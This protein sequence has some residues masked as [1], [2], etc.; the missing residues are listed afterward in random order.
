MSFRFQGSPIQSIISGLLFSASLLLAQETYLW[1]TNAS[2]ELS[3]SFG[4]YRSD[5]YHTGLDIRAVNK[6]NANIFAIAD[7]YIS[8]IAT[9][10][11]GYGKALYLTTT[12]GH[13]AVYG[14]LQSYSPKLES[15]LKIQ[16]EKSKS[17]MVDIHFGPKE[18][19]VLRGDVL[20]LVGDRGFSYGRHLHFE[21]RN[22]R[23]NPLNPLM[24]GF[25]IPDQ[26]APR[27]SQLAVIP[28]DSGAVVNAGV[29]PQTFPLYFDRTGIYLPPDT[30]NVFGKFGL[31]VE[32]LDKIEG[33]DFNYS[34][35]A[36]DL[37]IDDK[38][39]FRKKM[40]QLNFSRIRRVN[41]D[42]D[43]RLYRLNLG[44]FHRLFVKPAHAIPAIG[45]GFL[46]LS[47]GLHTAEID[48]YD[49]QGNRAAARVVLRVAAPRKLTVVLK[50][51]GKD[52]YHFSVSADTTLPLHKLTCYSF[53]GHGFADLKEDIKVTP[54]DSGRWDVAV[55]ASRCARNAL[56]FIAQ[57]KNGFFTDPA[58]WIPEKL[59]QS[60]LDS[61]VDLK[62]DPVEDG[63]FMQISID[64]IVKPEP[65]VYIYTDSKV[66]LMPM[67]RI[68][69]TVYISQRIEPELLDHV[70][71]VEVKLTGKQEL[72]T[73]FSMLP[74]FCSPVRRTEVYAPDRGCSMLLQPG[75]LYY[76]TAAWI[77]KVG[78]PVPSKTGIL[79]TP[80]YQL[81]PFDVPLKQ[82]IS[83]GIT[84]PEIAKDETDMGLFYFDSKEEKWTYTPTRRK[85]GRSILVGELKSFEAVAV[86]RDTIAPWVERRFP[87]ESGR[88]KW[89]D[90]DHIRAVINDDLSGIK[91]DETGIVLT[92][93]GKR[94][95]GDY[96]PVKKEFTAELDEPLNPGEHTVEW[97]LMDQTGNQAQKS[98]HFTVE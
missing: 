21:F 14:H 55:P 18:F 30:I 90:V 82:A 79:V 6:P 63:L 34:V 48:A 58:H 42:R 38:F 68:Q 70:Q 37:K 8:R 62:T 5:H 22:S 41:L 87:E 27:F 35:Y 84:F 97:S 19:P 7:G 73:R 44:S 16:Q 71:T 67:K 11:E 96:Q 60:V 85:P 81:Q 95:L 46:D 72:D 86:L 2:K 13:V 25:S 88:Y 93:D 17:Y 15:V 29:L 9:N 61:R 51:T 40:E 57:L 78:D 1:P 28:L 77:E 53:T 94:L 69:P 23:E 47:P 91:A 52:F 66:R 26:L 45:D 33:S 75:A 36:I 64:R 98:I 92:L 4:E 56:Q 12:D 32:A 39:Q 80:V 31:A 83:V 43:Y 74:G 20:G 3:S 10:F 54:Q 65:V 89:Q 76:Q 49:A 24:N 59:V 50:S